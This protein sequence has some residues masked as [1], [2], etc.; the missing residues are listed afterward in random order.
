M[1][2]SSISCVPTAPEEQSPEQPVEKETK[3]DIAP[4]DGAHFDIEASIAGWLPENAD[5]VSQTIAGLL[6]ED[7]AVFRSFV[8]STIKTIIMTELELD[9]DHI[10]PVEGEDSY[11]A[12]AGLGFPVLLELPLLGK[13]EYWITVSFDFII[14]EGQVLDANIDASSFNMNEVNN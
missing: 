9:V 11:S 6:P 2:I 7:F 12:R 5:N 4:G 8:A 3:A 1:T 13:K 10:E 14:K